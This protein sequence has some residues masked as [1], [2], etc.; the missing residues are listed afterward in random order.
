MPAWRA[1]A[2]L[3]ASVASVQTQTCPDWELLIVEDGSGDATLAVAQ[4][5]ARTDAR[6]RVISL[7]VNTGAAR[8]RNVGLAQARGRYIAF[9]DADDNWMPEKLARQLAFMARTGIAEQIGR[10]HV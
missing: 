3:P 2:T 7:P 8:A 10:A 1:A 4:A 5:L 9:L 6:I